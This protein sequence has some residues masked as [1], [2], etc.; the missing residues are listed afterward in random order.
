MPNVCLHCP[1]YD[2]LEAAADWAR[3]TL[4]DHLGDKREHVYTRE[5]FEQVGWGS[6]G[7]VG[8]WVGGSIWWQLDTRERL[9]QMGV[10]V[11]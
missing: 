7:W 4:N 3:Q 5:Q 11:R 2:S 6:A 8:G 10:G 9:E 1:R